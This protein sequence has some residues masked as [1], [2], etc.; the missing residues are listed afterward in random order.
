MTEP[1]PPPTPRLGAFDIGCV[2]VGGI[3]GVGIF[4]TPAVVAQRVS[5]VGQAMA[6]WGLGGFIA[7]LGALVFAE[8][9]LRQPGHGGTF[10]YVARAFGPLPA[11][12]YGWANTLVIQAGAAAIIAL[13]FVDNLD[14]VRF[15]GPTS[16]GLGKLMQAVAALAVFTF[17]NTI[18]LK[19]GKRTQNTLTVIK[20]LGVFAIV[21]LSLLPREAAASAEVVAASDR[22]VPWL[23]AIG[24]ALLPALFAFGGWQQGSFVAGAARRPRRD[25]PLGILAGVAVVVIAYMS[26]NLAYLELLGLGGARASSSI[27]AD[28]A[29]VALAP[30]GIG[31]ASGRLLAGIICISALGILNTILLAPP[32]V[33]HAMS[34][35]GLVPKS[36]GA[37]H[38]TSGTPRRAVLLQ[39]GWAIT[40]LVGA[41]LASDK[42][43]APLGFL[44][45]GVVFV[46]WIFYGMTGLALLTLRKQARADGTPDESTIP[47]AGLAAGLFV[48]SAVVVA[49]AAV[50]S[51]P[52]PSAAGLGVCLLGVAWYALWRRRRAA[53]P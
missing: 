36:L 18:G 27:G 2:V 3:I 5:S 44:I 10:R 1:P 28:A 50:V 31:E 38:A 6:A 13:I 40:L 33:L 48:A 29:R 34:R 37:L 26:V 46:D 7:L 21:V 25:V 16:S 9:A 15:G 23:T 32:F 19:A 39:G 20:T 11:F 14:I 51:S 45:D 12:L 41:T 49:G 24:A 22:D 17:V 42:A 47:G 30:F 4:F 43:K 35:E 52:A 53:Y 8:L